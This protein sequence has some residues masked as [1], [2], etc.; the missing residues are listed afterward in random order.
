MKGKLNILELNNIE[1][2][3]IKN[4]LS[5]NKKNE[6]KKREESIKNQKNLKEIKK[7]EIFFEKL[8]IN[9]LM[10][11]RDELIGERTFISKKFIKYQ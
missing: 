2:K 10:N 8:N 1:E 4:Y 6:K 5:L 9:E 11:L 7:K 3:E